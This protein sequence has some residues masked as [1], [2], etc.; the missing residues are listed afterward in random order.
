MQKMPKGLVRLSFLLD[1]MVTGTGF[2][3]HPPCYPLVARKQSDAVLFL[4]LGPVLSV[5]FR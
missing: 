1:S 4:Q 2:G 3:L 5:D